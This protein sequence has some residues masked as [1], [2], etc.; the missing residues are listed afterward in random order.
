M[1]Y[2]APLL[3]QFGIMATEPLVLLQAV[4]TSTRILERIRLRL[5]RKMLSDA[6]IRL[7]LPWLYAVPIADFDVAD[8]TSCDVPFSVTPVNL[9]Q[10]A[11]VYDWDFGNG[12]VSNQFEPTAVYTQTGTYNL[13][14]MAYNQFG[15]GDTTVQSIVYIPLRT[16]NLSRI[17][18]WVARI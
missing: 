12:T 1:N 3:Q 16:L 9:S 18:R 13:V 14:L 4:S 2:R 7:I 6:P 17:P 10:G 8:K 5:L 15:C 11:M